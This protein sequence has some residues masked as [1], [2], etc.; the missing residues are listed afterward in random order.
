MESGTIVEYIDQ[1]EIICA[2]VLEIKKQRLRVLTQSN[3]EVNLSSKR[4]IHQSNACLDTTMG[5]DHLINSLKEIVNTR[6]KFKN[7]ISVEEVWELLSSEAE[8]IDVETMAEFCFSE[9]ITSD[10]TSAIIRAFFGKTM[11]F[12]FDPGRFF[13]NS[14]EQVTQIL[15]KAEEEA[16]REA[17]INECAEWLKKIY[18][19]K[20]PE[21]PENKIKFV[22][23]LKSAYL[24][25]KESKDYELAKTILNRAGIDF[26]GGILKTMIKLG[27]WDENENLDLYRYATPVEF[28]HEVVDE[29]SKLTNISILSDKTTRRDLT[30]LPVI[31]IDG[32]ATTDHDDAISIEPYEKGYL[33]GIHIADVAG[34][35]KKGSSMDKQAMTRA[36]SIY[37]PEQKIPMLPPVLAEDLCSL[38]ADEIRPAISIMAKLTLNAEVLDFEI[39]PSI[40]R[41]A[42][43]FTYYDANLLI[44]EDPELDAFYDFAKKFRQKR[45][46]EGAV[47]INLPEIHIRIDEDNQINVNRV[48]RESPSRML[49][50]ETM[51]LGNWLMARFL[52]ENSVPTIFRSQ[53]GPKELILKN[54]EEGTLFQ[55]WMQRKLLSR[56][57]LSHKPECHCGLGM[58]CYAT[59]TSPIRKYF[60]LITQRQ[61]RSVMGLET[62]YSTT[63][64]KEAIQFLQQPM[65]RV[66]R[67]QFSRNRY[68]LMKYLEKNRSEKQEA[69]VLDKRWNNYILLLTKYLLECN[70]P[71]SSGLKLKPQDML[72]VSINRVNARNNIISVM[73]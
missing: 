2:V 13:P 41:V 59:A 60:D 47:Q 39:F 66:S 57:V 1:K 52:K 3:R 27:T 25:E 49:V 9:N 71:V 48:D 8:W 65:S 36:S 42:R 30:S 55:N 7:K 46:D 61:I 4:V 34:C 23:I 11:Y 26:E 35:I 51:I 72:Q 38:K 5:R 21:L 15:A 33:I 56:F 58:D 20:Y 53:P 37:M 22:D 18:K 17:M 31:T 68:W 24:F 45:L 29:A 10:H 28:P 73:V 43:K 32:Q 44:D 12:K 19:E 16:R 63:K 62:P 69:I 6:L 67:I 50:M 14:E 64:I 40:I 70:L 54:G